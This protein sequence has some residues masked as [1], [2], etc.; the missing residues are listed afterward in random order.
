MKT[1]A[2]YEERYKKPFTCEICHTKYTNFK[3]I[4]AKKKLGLLKHLSFQMI[5]YIAGREMAL[6]LFKSFIKSPLLWIVC[7]TWC[8]HMSSIVNLMFSKV[9]K[10][11]NA[12]WH[13]VHSSCF[14]SVYLVILCA[15]FI[16]VTSALNS[17][18]H[19]LQANGL[20]LW[21]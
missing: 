19:M 13:L 2:H 5:C 11:M 9:L 10:L 12:L 3:S 4:F 16:Q 15:G 14:T 7:D 1:S 20:S 8:R 18:W 6:F 21:I 17:F